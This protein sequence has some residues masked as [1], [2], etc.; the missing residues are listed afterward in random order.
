MK[1]WKNSLLISQICLEFLTGLVE[2]TKGIF[3]SCVILNVR[4]N[5]FC[6]YSLHVKSVA[7]CVAG[8]MG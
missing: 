6:I 7:S 8:E 3:S 5:G 4:Y 2:D 1:Y